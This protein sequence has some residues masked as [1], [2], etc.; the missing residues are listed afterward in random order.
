MNASSPP[1]QQPSRSSLPAVAGWWPRIIGHD[2]TPP[3]T[4]LTAEAAR[5]ALAAQ[6]NIVQVALAPAGPQTL[7]G[8]VVF[9]PVRQV[10]YL[11]FRG[12]P[13]ND[14]RQA[15]YQLWIADAGR[16][17]PEPVD[18]GVFDVGGTSTAGGDVIIPFHARLA[19]GKA[20]AH[21]ARRRPWVQYSVE[22]KNSRIAA[23]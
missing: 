14:P 15:Q 4:Q 9:D 6:Q 7:T 16:A 21:R 19:V 20:A 10:G 11:R 17:Q 23:A 2:A 12:I 13:A 3:T 22:R 5:A 18:G 1:R 8:D